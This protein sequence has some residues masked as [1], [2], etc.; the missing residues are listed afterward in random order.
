MV[1]TTSLV[2]SLAL[3]GAS[4]ATTFNT[5]GMALK[6]EFAKTLTKEQMDIY[7]SIIEHRMALYYQGLIVGLVFGA[8]YI[9]GSEKKEI[10]SKV[11]MFALI[12]LGVQY[13]Y[14]MIAPK[15]QWM[16]DHITTQEQASKWLDIY[17]YMSKM[18]HMGFLMA[19]L[20][21]TLGCYAYLK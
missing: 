21:S 2:L 6:S 7:E 9:S 11:A 3:L 5:K 1:C 17:Q 10:A 20:G 16:L 15:G 19:L 12:V 18:W 8:V 4:I 14:Y 13:M